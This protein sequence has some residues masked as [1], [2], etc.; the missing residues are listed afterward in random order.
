MGGV[1][2]GD[3]GVGTGYGYP[4]AGGGYFGGAVDSWKLWLPL[5]ANF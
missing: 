3:Q 1:A 2:V 4:G 5:S